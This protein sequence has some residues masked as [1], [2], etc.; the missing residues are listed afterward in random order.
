[1][2]KV[3]CSECFYNTGLR[4][5]AANIGDRSDQPCQNCLSR[6]GAGLDQEAL[7]K[8]MTRFFVGGSRS[9]IPTTSLPN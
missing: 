9:P 4:V 2:E 1:M 7:A 6:N 3:L 5:E 8:L